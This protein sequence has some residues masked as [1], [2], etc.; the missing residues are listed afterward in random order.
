MTTRSRQGLSRRRTRPSR[1]ARARRQPAR[2]KR[3]RH[4]LSERLTPERT[5]AMEPEHFR[6]Y[7]GPV[8]VCHRVG[9]KTNGLSIDVRSGAQASLS[10]DR[11]ATKLY[12]TKPPQDPRVARPDR[13]GR[14]GSIPDARCRCAMRSGRPTHFSALRLER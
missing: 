2:C 6:R 4:K 13:T 5:H 7:D 14:E 3:T 1:R 9:S 10:G 12:N 11:D 8:D